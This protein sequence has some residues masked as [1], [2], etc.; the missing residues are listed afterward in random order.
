MK[1]LIESTMMGRH[2]KLLERYPCLSDFG[3]IV[4]AEEKHRNVPIKDENGTRIYQVVRDTV[5]TP[6]ILLDSLDDLDRLTKACGCPLIYSD[7][8]NDYRGVRSIEIY[9]DYRE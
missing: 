3:Y 5:F 2:E 1:C 6:Y 7:E 9:D 4:E 8:T